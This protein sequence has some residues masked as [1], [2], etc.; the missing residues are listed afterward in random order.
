MI[1][2]TH[3]TTKL[4]KLCQTKS[5]RSQ[6]H[7]HG[8]VWNID[9]SFYNGCGNQHVNLPR[10]ELLHDR[11]LFFCLQLSVQEFNRT[12]VKGTLFE[13]F[14]CLHNRGTSLCV[15]RINKRTHHKH[16]STCTNLLEHM[17]PHTLTMFLCHK[18]GCDWFATGWKF[19]Q[20]GEI[21]IAVNS[22][23]KRTRNRC[24]THG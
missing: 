8:C 21:K 10:T 13:F 3:A 15:R 5:F 23:S 6:N 22:Q 7:H 9:P 24:C 16:L 2:S 14:F 12:G 18:S 1:G 4:M 20:N 19:V 17:F 11:F